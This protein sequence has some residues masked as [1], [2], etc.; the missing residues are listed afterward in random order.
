MCSS[1]LE[2]GGGEPRSAHHG[3]H[4]VHGEPW[5]GDPRRV[6][7]G[8]V[9]HHVGTGIGQRTEFAGNGDAVHL[10]AD[11]LRIDGGH[12]AQGRVG[13]NGTTHGG[14]HTTA[15]PD[16]TDLDGRAHGLSTS[17]VTT[18]ATAIAAVVGAFAGRPEVAQLAGQLGVEC[19]VERHAHCVAALAT[20]GAL[21]ATATITAAT[22]MSSGPLLVAFVL[23]QRQ[24]VQSF[25][26][27]GIK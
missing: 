13:R 26:R 25:M 2:V 14:T 17:A 11:S 23:F 5:Q 15:R 3:M 21:A 7:D 8:E 27:A 24:F 16:H 1:D 9:D 19:V 10:L 20:I 6:G 18:A 22:L 4:P 12:E